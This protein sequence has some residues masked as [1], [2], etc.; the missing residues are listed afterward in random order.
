MAVMPKPDDRTPY[1]LVEGKIV[2]QMMQTDDQWGLYDLDR[3]LIGRPFRH[4][5]SRSLRDLR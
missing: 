4:D 5:A 2:G 3:N 1:Q